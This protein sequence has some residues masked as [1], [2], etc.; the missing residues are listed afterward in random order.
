VSDNVENSII[1]LGQEKE[2]DEKVLEKKCEGF[3]PESSKIKGSRYSDSTGKDDDEPLVKKLELAQAGCRLHEFDLLFGTAALERSRRRVHKP[4]RYED[5][6]MI[7]SKRE[8]QNQRHGHDG[9]SSDCESESHGLSSPS[10]KRKSSDGGS[11]SS[12]KGQK[13]RHSAED[14]TGK[15][16]Q[17]P[18]SS[19]S[20]PGR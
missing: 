1:S 17:S 12:P 3:T 10:R 5:K 9:N 19:S 15:H 11:F 8:K 2:Y 13:R 14:V 6:A 20:T 4:E 7:E 16:L 18:V